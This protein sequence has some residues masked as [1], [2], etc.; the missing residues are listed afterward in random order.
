MAQNGFDQVLR[1]L[2]AGAAEFQARTGDTV[3]QVANSVSR[4]LDE[5][6][7]EGVKIKQALVR[8]WTTLERPR[9]SRV[10]VLIGL[11]GLGVAAA[12]FARRAASV[13]T[14]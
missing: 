8:N 3:A 13:S 4:I 12:Y 6:G 10:P 1:A 9:R 7:T 11:V 5:A 14:S 2:R